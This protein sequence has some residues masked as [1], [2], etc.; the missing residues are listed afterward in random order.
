M[1]LPFKFYKRNLHELEQ[2]INIQ[3]VRPNYNY[4]TV[5][6]KSNNDYE[7][8]RYPWHSVASFCLPGVGQF[9]KG[10]KDKGKRDLGIHIGVALSGVVVAGLAM[11]KAS[12]QNTCF[13]NFGY[14]DI[15]SG[16]FFMAAMAVS[17]VNRIHSAY[18]AYKA[19][20]RYNK[21]KKETPE[22]SQAE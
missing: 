6:F 17:T 21:S 12:K 22:V 9:I 14:K 11:L 7:G 19:A 2:E 10:D 18:D 4:N 13:N 20:P 16:G 1:N 8:N 5:S 15:L 3:S